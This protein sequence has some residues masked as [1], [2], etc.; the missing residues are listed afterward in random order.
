[1]GR[2]GKQLIENLEKQL[3]NKITEKQQSEKLLL[4]FAKTVIY[5]LHTDSPYNNYFCFF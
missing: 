1:M 2:S 5:Q 3:V 4:A